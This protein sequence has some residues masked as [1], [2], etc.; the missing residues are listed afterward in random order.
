MTTEEIYNSIIEDSK[1][2]PSFINTRSKEHKMA[3]DILSN[4][5]FMT[6]TLIQDHFLTENQVVYFVGEFE[7]TA[8]QFDDINSMTLFMSCNQ[9]IT[10][11][12]QRYHDEALEN[13]RYEVA[14]NLKRFIDERRQ[15]TYIQTQDE[16]NDS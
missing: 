6:S 7:E 12:I 1:R 5:I 15:W 9:Y 3:F 16:G 2:I 14:A 4:L 8:S 11:L 13:E 10:N